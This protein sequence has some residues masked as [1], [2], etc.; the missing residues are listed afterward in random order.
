MVTQIASFTDPNTEYDLTIEKGLVID[1]TCNSRHFN[2][3]W[4]CKHMKAKQA[5]VNAEIERAARFLALKA[6]IEVQE[7]EARENAACYHRMMISE[8]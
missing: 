1:C 4:Q 3:G 5:E 8:W 6:Q 2:P 7:R